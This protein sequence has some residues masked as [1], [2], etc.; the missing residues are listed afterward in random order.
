MKVKDLIERLTKYNNLDDE[1]IVDY[2]AHDDVNSWFEDSFTNDE[3][4]KLIIE[5]EKANI[6]N[7]DT[8]HIYYI[9]REIYKGGR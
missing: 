9:A 4:E 2:L 7:L 3:W 1:I 5:S 6:S 8:D